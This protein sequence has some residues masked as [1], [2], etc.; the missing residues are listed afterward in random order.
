MDER[1]DGSIGLA[2]KR[3]VLSLLLLL[4]WVLQTA[5][6]RLEVVARI[7]GRD[8]GTVGWSDWRPTSASSRDCGSI[9]GTLVVVLAVAVA[10]LAGG[11][12]AALKLGDGGLAEVCTLV[13]GDLGQLD[14]RERN[15][16][17]EKSQIQLELQGTTFAD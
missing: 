17:L 13:K 2:A 7:G 5:D 3:T 9:V 14:T 12:A 16:L 6:L 10:A 11:N 15:L 4:A 8:Y 1:C